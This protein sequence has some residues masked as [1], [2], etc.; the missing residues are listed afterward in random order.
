VFLQSL[1]LATAVTVVVRYRYSHDSIVE[2]KSS[3][4]PL[5]LFS[6]LVATITLFS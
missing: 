1:L 6:E 4:N 5:F 2:Y 3:R